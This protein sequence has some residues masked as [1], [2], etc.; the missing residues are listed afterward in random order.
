MRD[1][2]ARLPAGFEV[3]CIDAAL[4]A[5]DTLQN[6]NIVTRWIGNNWRSH[7]DFLEHGFGFCVLDVA[8]HTLVSFCVADCVCGNR[9]EVGIKTVARV[10]RAW[11]GGHSCSRDS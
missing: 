6:L 9:A 7:I 1:W 8:A 2:R 11:A 4:L 10:S 5:R 3:Q